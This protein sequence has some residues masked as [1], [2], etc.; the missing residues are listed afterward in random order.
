MGGVDQGG[1]VVISGRN[2]GKEAAVLNARIRKR[3]RSGHLKVG[4][5]GA[6]ADLTY[7]YDYLG[8]GADSLAE[9]AGGKGSFADV[10]KNAKN[11]IILVGS[12]AAAR[13]DGA[14]VL[15]L[16]AKLALAV[17]AIK[18]GWNGFAVLHDTASRVRALDIR[19]SAGGGGAAPGPAG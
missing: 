17:G 8:A 5:I 13:H 15:A 2:A 19:L 9:L 4:L 16:A 7:G 10:L 3:W 11:P 14:A 18:D 1:G 12:G 6:R